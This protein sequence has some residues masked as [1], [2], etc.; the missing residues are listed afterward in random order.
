[1]PVFKKAQAFREEEGYIPNIRVAKWAVAR[2][3]RLLHSTEEAVDI[4]L[5]LNEEYDVLIKSGK[6]DMPE[7]MLLY[8]HGLLQE[9]IA[10]IYSAKAKTFS[11]RA[12]EALS[13]NEWIKK[14]DPKKLERLKKL[15]EPE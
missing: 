11:G 3:L 15:K 8:A 10:E 7:E 9:E 12:Y 6:L 2:T 1:M 13:Q 14:L 5:A 4:L